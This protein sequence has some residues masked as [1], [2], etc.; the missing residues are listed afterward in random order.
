MLF[1]RH[2][3]IYYNPNYFSIKL[4][5]SL[6]LPK[7]RLARNVPLIF[8]SPTQGRVYILQHT[9]YTCLDAAE[10]PPEIPLFACK[11]AQDNCL[12]FGLK[13][14]TLC[15]VISARMYFERHTL[16]NPPTTRL[17]YAT[18][19]SRNARSK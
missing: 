15:Q 16:R 6:N 17:Q 7:L 3:Y 10:L 4:N 13:T 9:F 8:C 2:F 1:F 5:I 19:A 18:V 14:Y 12:F 11:D